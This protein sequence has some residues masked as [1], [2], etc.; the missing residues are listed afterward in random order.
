M[1]LLFNKMIG[2]PYYGARRLAPFISFNQIVDSF[3]ISPFALNVNMHKFYLLRPS[4]FH[5][6]FS[7]SL[8]IFYL[9]I[10]ALLFRRIFSTYH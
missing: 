4:Y 3:S 1:H 5:R 2:T 8:K 10:T 9:F 7:P 6:F